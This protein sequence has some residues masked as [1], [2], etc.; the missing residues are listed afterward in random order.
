MEE[1]EFFENDG[2]V[3]KNLD[4][5]GIT[6]IVI[7]NYHEYRKPNSNASYG[8]SWEM[9]INERTGVIKT[10]IG[11]HTEQLKNP[12]AGLLDCEKTKLHGAILLRYNENKDCTDDD[13]TIVLL[14]KFT[15]CRKVDKKTLECETFYGDYYYEEPTFS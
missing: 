8:Y 1:F 15:K 4:N 11:Y 12:S 5:C 3:K 2:K 10:V 14:D 9:E 13:H 6:D 7:E